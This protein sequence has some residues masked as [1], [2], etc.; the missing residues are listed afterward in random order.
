MA[1]E[2]IHTYCAICM[3]RCGVIATVDD[4]RFVKVERDPEHPNGC[5]CIK[6]TAAPEM[7][8][9]PDRIRQ[10]MKRTRPKSDPDPG[11]APISWEDAIEIMA[12]R[13]EEIRKN[14]GPEA[15]IFGR[16]TPAGSGI[17]EFDP[18]LRRFSNAF[19]SPNYLTTTHLC[20]WHKM[21]GAKFTFGTPTPPVDYANTNCILLWGFNPQAT[22]PDVAMRISRA[23]ARGA[24]LIVIDPRETDLARKADCWLRVRPGSDAALALSMIHVLIEEGLY[25]EA[26]VR[27]WTNGP[28]LVQAD[29]NTLLSGTDL[30]AAEAQGSFVVWDENNGSPT[31]YHRDRGYSERDVHPALTGS[32]SCHLTGSSAVECRPV[33]DLLKERASGYAPELSSDTTW[34]PADELRRAVRLFATER[35]SCLA[36]W[37][38]LEQHSD[39][40]QINRA[41]SCFY[42]LTGQFDQRGSNVLFAATPLTPM[43]AGNLLPKEM[44]KRRLGIEKHPLGPQKEPGN[45]QAEKFYDAVLDGQ[46]YPVKAAIFFGSDTLINA[47]ETVRGKKALEM[48]EFYVHVDIV[49][50]ASAA[51][52]DLLLP[53]CTP[54]EHEAVKTLNPF[55]LSD[56]DLANWS[57][58]RKAVVPPLH[59]AR[60]DLEILFDLAERLGLGEHFFGGD[61]EAA[62]NAHLEPSGL[63]IQTLREHP[64]G[65]RSDVTTVFQ[66]Y[67]QI[68]AESGLARGFP[69]PSGKLEL[70]STQLA[71]VGCSPLPEYSEP[72]ESPLSV[73][74]TEQDFPLVLTFYRQVQFVNQQHR[75]IPRLRRQVPE[76]ILELHPD[77][78]AAKGI[79]DG[80]WAIVEN[81]TGRVRLKAKFNESLDPRVVCAPYGWWQECKEL[82]LPGYEPFGSDSASGNNLIADK[83]IDPISGTAPHRSSMCRVTALNAS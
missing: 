9:S 16:A 10:P 7:V 3:S 62:W 15:V 61:V 75:N 39:S 48:L 52:A 67:S 49:P 4:G 54:W 83:R 63:T 26:F 45:V 42:G 20:N 71:E 34:V 73:S 36:T 55:L 2:R 40:T 11:W 13:L 64:V 82:G 31:T 22:S 18:W 81:S 32:Y 12:S 74:D 69:T 43:A 50:N 28:F 1:E 37:V 30:N 14:H 25:D 53:A 58:L 38:G 35:P 70:Y 23:R 76:P 6:G 33:F 51:F 60:P 19:G 47:N 59:D 41:V 44:L 24:K 29:T 78:A 17:Q 56:P 46:P 79:Q 72:A 68:E 5:I 57:Q 21:F 27:D 8:Y 65:I 77:T 80:D 66:K